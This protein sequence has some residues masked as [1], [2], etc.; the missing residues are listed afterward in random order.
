MLLRRNSKQT[1]LEFSFGDKDENR[2]LV[3]YEIS[4][5]HHDGRAFLENH[6]SSGNGRRDTI[7]KPEDEIEYI[8]RFVNK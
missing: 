5:I 4:D 7:C 3:S 8:L 2:F 6:L 1:S